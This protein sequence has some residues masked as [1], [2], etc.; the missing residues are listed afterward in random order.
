MIA[1][2]I[3]QGEQGSIISPSTLAFS[4]YIPMTAAAPPALPAAARS[5]R[6]GASRITGKPSHSLTRSA[7]S[8]P[9]MTP[10]L[11][12]DG[13]PGSIAD[14]NDGA[15]VERTQ[16]ERT[17]RA[18]KQHV[19]VMNEGPGRIPTHMI[20]RIWRN[21]PDEALFTR[22]ARSPLTWLRSY[23]QRHRRHD[24]G[25]GCAKRYASP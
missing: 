18:L 4:C 14:A 15:F 25:H 10:F 17:Q 5:W 8:W 11:H 21:N 1:T 6:N 7:R 13:P 19:Q 12:H 16:G 24:R 9:P 23:H 20:M 22:W 2:F 3:E